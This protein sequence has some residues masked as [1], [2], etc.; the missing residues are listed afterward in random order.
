MIPVPIEANLLVTSSC[1]LSCRHC[2]VTSHGPLEA[3]LSP[4]EWG[5]V[6]Q[7]LQDARV[8]RLTITGG[9]PFARPD[10]DQIIG[11][12]MSRP[13]RFTINTNGT[14]LDRRAVR[15]LLD[16]RRRLDDLMIGLDGSC[17]EVVDRLRGAGTFGLQMEGLERLASS[18]IRPGFYCTV[19]SI[20]RHDLP[21]VLRLA[22]RYGRWIKF[23]PFVISGPALD[24]KLALSPPEYVR[25][26]RELRELSRKVDFQVLGVIPDML[27]ALEGDADGRWPAFGCGALRSKVSVMP[28]GQVAPCDHLP[29]LRLGS[30]L[31]S[32]LEEIL[33]GE[34]A[35]GIAETIDRGLREEPACADCSFR[36]RCIG[37][38]PVR[39]LAGRGDRRDPYSCLRLMSGEDGSAGDA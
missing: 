15:L 10:L 4:S 5:T 35:A 3:D 34:A 39:A 6:L 17:P 37:G 30:L 18:G 14:L 19:T 38:C 22:N 25:V 2:T 11:Q 26:A 28:N 13:F 7:R 24:R 20:N 8:L 23:N 9:E 29:G 1:N 36:E 32:S 31:D 33:R 27:A 12:V 21:G 16:S